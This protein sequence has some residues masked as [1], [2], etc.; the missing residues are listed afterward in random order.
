[1]DLQGNDVPEELDV[2]VQYKQAPTSVD[3]QR[4]IV[5]GGVH[6]NTF[7][8]IRAGVYHVRANTIRD[9][10]SDPNVA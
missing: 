3:H 7:N 4:V 10:A 9:L 2:I 1:M 8:S 6:R 5:R